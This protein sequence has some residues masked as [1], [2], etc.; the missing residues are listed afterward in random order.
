MFK[1][2]SILRPRPYLLII[3]KSKSASTLFLLFIGLFWLTWYGVLIG[4]GAPVTDFKLWLFYLAPLMSLPQILHSIKIITSGEFF[5]FDSDRKI[6]EKDGKR[7]AHFDDV[8]RLQ[9]RTFED[10]EGSD[11]HRLSIVCNDNKKIRIEQTSDFQLI[12]DAAD[13]IADV[14]NVKVIRK[15]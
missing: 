13:D 7:L 10:S 5:A 15:K 12:C 3:K 1:S 6:I 11:E 4:G 8:E 9:I 14:L 2:F